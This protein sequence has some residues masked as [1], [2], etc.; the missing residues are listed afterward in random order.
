MNVFEKTPK[1]ADKSTTSYDMLDFK[2][3]KFFLRTVLM[4]D[5]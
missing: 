2:V 5:W 1:W 4:V 3:I